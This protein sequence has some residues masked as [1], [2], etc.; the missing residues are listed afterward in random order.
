MKPEY[1]EGREVADKFEEA[2]KI[3]FRT[4]KPKKKQSKAANERKIKDS[5]KD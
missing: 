1:K 5:D 4:P 3:I 2:M